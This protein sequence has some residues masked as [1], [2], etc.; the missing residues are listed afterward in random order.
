MRIKSKPILLTALAALLLSGCATNDGIVET[1]MGSYSFSVDSNPG[2]YVYPDSETSEATSHSSIEISFPSTSSSQSSGEAS[3][4]T[5]IPSS[6]SEESSSGEST[7]PVTPSNVH[8]A[9]PDMPES[10]AI[11]DLQFVEDDA[12]YSSLAIYLAERELASLGLNVFRA[13]AAIPDEEEDAE[14]PKYVL[15]GIAFSDGSLYSYDEDGNPYYSCGFM[16]IVEGEPEYTLTPEIAANGVAVTPQDGSDTRFIIESNAFVDGFSGL[17]NGHYFSYKQTAPFVITVSSKKVSGPVKDFA[18]EDL[19][20]YDYDNQEYLYQAS[21]FKGST[22]GAYAIYG[23]AAIAYENAV[24]AL[25][26]AIRIQEENGMVLALNSFVVFDTDCLNAEIGNLQ[27]E[28]GSL[29][30]FELAQNQY[31]VATEDG[32]QVITDNSY[33]TARQARGFSG[34]LK[35]LTGAA[36]TGGGAML[37][38]TG[39]TTFAT[40]PV[41]GGLMLLSGAVQAVFGTADVVE[42]AQDIIACTTGNIEM[43]SYNPIKDFFRNMFGDD[44]AGEKAYYFCEAAIGLTNSFFGPINMALQSSSGLAGGFSTAIGVG[45]VMAVHAAKL[46]ITTLVAVQAGKFAQRAASELGLSDI[47]SQIIG[48]GVSFVTGF[49]VYRGLDKIDRAFNLSGFS[50]VRPVSLEEI[51]NERAK[52]HIDATGDTDV[53]D[54]QPSLYLEKNSYSRKVYTDD[55][56]SRISTEQGVKLKYGL[57]YF[58]ESNEPFFDYFPSMRYQAEQSKQTLVAGFLDIKTMT[59]F[60]DFDRIKGDG[61]LM[62]RTVAHLM[63][64][65]HQLETADFDSPVMRALREENYVGPDGSAYAYLNNEAEKDAEAYADYIQARS[66]H[67]Y[68]VRNQNP[69]TTYVENIYSFEDPSTYKAG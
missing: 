14:D 28:F 6:S 66:E 39:L 42:A 43:E 11:E 52:N 10:M 9:S 32:Y 13:F 69:G 27:E 57:R 1:S 8:Y 29:T 24:A 51:R 61:I 49:L 41:L 15:P 59:I 60:L 48:I 68:E 20:L 35:T 7:A 33:E 58:T 65:I 67:A 47:A 46:G 34:L 40:C 45:R 4:E 26:E 62:L 19:D 17:S 16:Q 5:S 23:K 30:G 44:E 50:K 22:I 36:M 53:A 18:D 21:I 64:H 31:I 55:T 56:V 25:D 3:S 2:S 38:V 12:Y 37:M 54:G 63:R